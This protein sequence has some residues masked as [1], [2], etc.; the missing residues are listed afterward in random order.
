MRERYV[1]WDEEGDEDPGESP[2]PRQVVEDFNVEWAAEEYA[3]RIHGE[4]DWAD[5]VTIGV[6]DASGK[7]HI[8][9]VDVEA[10]PSFSGRVRV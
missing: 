8:V 9:D 4:S 6:R 10:V 1:C 7:V 3:E 5:R 2:S